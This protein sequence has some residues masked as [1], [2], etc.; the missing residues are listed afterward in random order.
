MRIRT[1]I[2]HALSLCGIAL[3]TLSSLF[4]VAGQSGAVSGV[5]VH[6]ED[7]VCTVTAYWGYYTGYDA[8]YVTA[9]NC[10]F[11][12]TW[13]ASCDYE[14]YE[15]NVVNAVGDYSKISSAD[16]QTLSEWCYDNTGGGYIAYLFFDGLQVA[17]SLDNPWPGTYTHTWLIS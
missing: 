12:V 5:N 16:L 14:S 4:I 13:T 3:L 9:D 7:T 1:K 15:G 17:N 11:P 2:H 10:A 6:P 8:A